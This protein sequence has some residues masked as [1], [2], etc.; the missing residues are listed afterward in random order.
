MKEVTK[1][2]STGTLWGYRPLAPARTTVGFRLLVQQ[3]QD[4][5]VETTNLRRLQNLL[6]VENKY[7]TLYNQRPKDVDCKA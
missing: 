6:I 4:Q 2:P 5:P 7:I 1:T 3:R